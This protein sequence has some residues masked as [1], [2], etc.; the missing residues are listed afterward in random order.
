MGDIIRGAGLGLFSRAA[1]SEVFCSSFVLENLSLL[2][3]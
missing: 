3:L 2:S 1:M